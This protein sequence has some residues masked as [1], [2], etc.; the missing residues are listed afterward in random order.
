MYKPAVIAFTTL[1]S[2]FL[3]L[4]FIKFERIEYNQLNN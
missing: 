2:R 1:N 3:F 4:A